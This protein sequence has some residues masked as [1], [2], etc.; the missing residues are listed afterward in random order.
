ME[1][2]DFEKLFPNAI[3]RGKDFEVYDMSGAE[4]ALARIERKVATRS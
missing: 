2:D 3:K 1:K 4:F